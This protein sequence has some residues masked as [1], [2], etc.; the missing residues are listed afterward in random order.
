MT[1]SGKRYDPESKKAAASKGRRTAYPVYAPLALEQCLMSEASRE[2]ESVA[3]SLADQVPASVVVKLLA[4]SA[5]IEKS[6]QTI[7]RSQSRRR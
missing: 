4:L 3:Y 6:S 1:L 2:I 7:K 5:K